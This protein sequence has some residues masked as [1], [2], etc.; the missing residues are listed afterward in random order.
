MACIGQASGLWRAGQGEDRDKAQDASMC[1]QAV[2]QDG[3]TAH[4]DGLEGA[5]REKYVDPQGCAE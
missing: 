5:Y 4:R 1:A 2:P 3:T